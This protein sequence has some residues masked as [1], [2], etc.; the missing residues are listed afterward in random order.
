MRTIIPSPLLKTALLADALVSGAV[1][2]TQLAA[3]DWLSSF[4]RLPRT[5]LFETGVFLVLYTALLLVLARS[6]R[7]PSALVTTIVLGNVGW[8]IGCAGLLIMGGA[9]PSVMGVAFVV[10]QAVA[11]LVFAALEY[12][13]LESSERVPE[14]QAMATR[15]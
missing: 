12:R 9:A 15:G 5:L 4:L 13:G 14:R 2:I 1:A 3:T 10:V 8:A 7:M 6:A 11:V